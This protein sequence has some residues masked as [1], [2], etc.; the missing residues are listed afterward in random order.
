MSPDPTSPNPASTE[1]GRSDTGP[2]ESAPTDSMSE[3]D[4]ERVVSYVMRRARV[5]PL[6]RR[7]LLARPRVALEEELNLDLPD[8]FRIRFV[9][10]QGADLTIVLPDP[11]R[12]HGTRPP[13]D[14]RRRSS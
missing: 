12:P 5:D 10:N 4:A 11:V 3:E 7:A 2:S 14:T 1:G 8:D 13:I 6:F 9:E